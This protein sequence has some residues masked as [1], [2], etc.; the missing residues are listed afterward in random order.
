MI[1]LKIERLL[2]LACF[3][4]GLW[5]EAVVFRVEGITPIVQLRAVF[6]ALVFTG[7]VY[8]IYAWARKTCILRKIHRLQN[9]SDSAA[10]FQYVEQCAQKRPDIFWL[11]V[12][13]LVALITLGRITDAR[14]AV[15]ALKSNKRSEKKKFHAVICCAQELIAYLAMEEP[16]H[17]DALEWNNT[18]CLEKTVHIIR[19]RKSAAPTENLICATCKI[20]DL[21]YPMFRSVAALLLAEFYHEFGNSELQEAYGKRALEHAPSDEVRTAVETHLQ[22]LTTQPDGTA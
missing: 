6:G 9:G 5:L 1:H 11:R 2:L 17:T 20:Y 12:E 15:C 16:A 10:Y 21:P 8:G 7:A 4:G 19:Q 18:G 14:A 22:R 13:K 3:I